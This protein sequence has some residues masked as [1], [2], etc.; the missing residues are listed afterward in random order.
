MICGG[1]YLY[2]FSWK[3][4]IQKIIPKKAMGNIHHIHFFKDFSRFS[5]GVRTSENN[6]F[7]LV[8]VTFF[9]LVIL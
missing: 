9:I 5:L 6:G 7:D 1:A 3:K 2:V 8:S 4:K